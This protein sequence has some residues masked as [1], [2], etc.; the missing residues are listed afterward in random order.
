[1][2]IVQKTF[3]LSLASIALAIPQTQWERR[4]ADTTTTPAPTSAN[5]CD[6]GP[7][8]SAVDCLNSFPSLVPSFCDGFVPEVTT[9]AT[10]TTNPTTTVYTTIFS[11]TAF[12]STNI[13]TNSSVVTETTTVTQNYTITSGQS[14]SFIPVQATETITSYDYICSGDIPTATAQPQRAKRQANPTASCSAY[15]ARYRNNNGINAACSCVVDSLPS[16]TTITETEIV[17]TGTTVTLTL[18]RNN[19]GVLTSGVTTSTS[20]SLATVTTTSI[21]SRNATVPNIVPVLTTTGTSY[22]TT[23]LTTATPIPTSFRLTVTLDSQN[24]TGRAIDVNDGRALAFYP[25]AGGND[26]AINADSELVNNNLF[27]TVLTEVAP[28]DIPFLFW[29]NPEQV[30][31]DQDILGVSAC[32][33]TLSATSVGAGE[34]F[35]LCEGLNENRLLA[36][37]SRE[38]FENNPETCAV[39]EVRL[40]PAFVAVPSNSTV[41]PRGVLGARY[42]LM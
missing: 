24:L 40:D 30:P 16:A 5:T 23:T 36:L 38:L 17:P 3:I 7:T 20:I 39:V 15:L 34:V 9:T 2:S 37:G 28:N 6:V 12:S 13:V 11:S 41:T 8:S 35:A 31:R 33:G 10:I 42:H 29:Q 32:N 26:F 21:E 14:T 4:Q 22:T 25:D 27:L 19:R 18:T 1:M